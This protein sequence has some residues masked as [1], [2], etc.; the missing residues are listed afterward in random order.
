MHERERERQQ[1]EPG[2]AEQRPEHARPQAGA[3]GELPP[4]QRRHEGGARELPG[5]GR[6]DVERPVG[7]GR[8]QPHRRCQ[9]HHERP[10]EQHPQQTAGRDAG[11][12]RQGDG[13]QDQQRPEDVELLLDAER[14]G[15]QVRARG[16]GVG[17]VVLP[18][19]REQQVGDEQH[20]RRPVPREAG[21]DQ[22]RQDQDAPE[23]RDRHDQ[24]ERRYQPPHAA[25]PELDEVDGP[26]A[27]HLAQKQRADE[28]AG[29]H[30][31][32]VDA[33]EPAGDRDPR[34]VDDDGEHSD[35]A[36]P[37]DVGAE[38]VPCT[39]RGGSLV[40]PEA[41]RLRGRSG[42][43]VDGGRRLRHF[44]PA[45][46][47]DGASHTITG[48]MGQVARLSGRGWG[49]WLSPGTRGSRPAP[50]H[51]RY[52]RRPRTRSRHAAAPCRRGCPG[53]RASPA[54]P[55]RRPAAG[56]RCG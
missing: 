8:R 40:D 50:G 31:E 36:Q 39:W 38:R 15:V 20:G 33:G 17:E 14:P 43:S 27:V 53:A 42:G 18:L 49:E 9:R 12:P 29:D 35:R 47:P 5:A 24:R 26:V 4:R 10:R 46:V 11:A 13:Q 32:D 16:D 41:A 2:G 56:W 48:A 19:V 21:P 22:R 1:R 7:R 28:V 3:F 30:V 6:Q 55:A 25:R 54:T 45:V 23:Q 34:V 44:S 37:V 51:R 52:R